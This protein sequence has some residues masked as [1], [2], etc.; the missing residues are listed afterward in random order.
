MWLTDKLRELLGYSATEQVTYENFLMRVHEEDRLAVAQAA[1]QA[2]RRNG[3]FHSEYRVVLPDGALRWFSGRGQVKVDVTGVPMQMLGVVI[4]ITERH[5]VEE[6]ARQLSGKL[7]T[8]QEDERKRIARDLH[9]DLNQR[10]ALLSVEMQL[11][12]SASTDTS[13]PARERL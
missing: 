10:L 6:E 1:Q 11:F 8:A 3:R 12:G 4:D 13:G 9:D 5:R 7:I 2:L